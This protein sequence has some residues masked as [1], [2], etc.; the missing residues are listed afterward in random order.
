VCMADGVRA[1]R[2]CLHMHLIGIF[3]RRR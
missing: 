1:A 3:C 2:R